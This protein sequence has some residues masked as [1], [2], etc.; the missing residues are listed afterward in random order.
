LGV[1]V[2]GGGGAGFNKQM[3]KLHN[4]GRGGSNIDGFI[5]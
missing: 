1:G 4:G 5:S 2:E 3:H